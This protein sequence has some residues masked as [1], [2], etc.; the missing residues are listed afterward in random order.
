M[1]GGELRYVT[2]YKGEQPCHAVANQP[3]IGR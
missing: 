3:A 1:S 2:Q